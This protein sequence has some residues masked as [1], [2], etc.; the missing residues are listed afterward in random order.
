MKKSQLLKRIKKSTFIG[1]F[2]A[3]DSGFVCS[4]LLDIGWVLLLA[5]ILALTAFIL[6]GTFSEIAKI[7]PEL[8]NALGQ[9]S[10]ED[11]GAAAQLASIRAVLRSIVIK[12][13]LTAAISVISMIIASAF[14]RSLVWSRLTLRKLDKGYIKRLF[15]LKLWWIPVW[16][17]IMASVALLFKPEVSKWVVGVIALAYFHFTAVL[18]LLF[19]KKKEVLPTIKKAFA[20][21]IKKFHFFIIPYLLAAVILSII[22]SILYPLSML[23]IN[24]TALT[25]IL[26]VVF[27]VFAAWLRLYIGMVVEGIEKA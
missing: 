9:I 2:K 3:I 23:Q 24:I 21:G 8:N 20:A 26:V 25:G 7:T 22:A 11:P 5:G 4:F 18:H 6:K 14:L 13:G 12:A 1:S 15:L 16:L 27:L 17:I 10:F 19:E